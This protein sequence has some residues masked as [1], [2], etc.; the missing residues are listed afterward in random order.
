MYHL[1]LPLYMKDIIRLIRTSTSM[2]SVKAAA[3]V[4]VPSLFFRMF[5]VA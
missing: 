2:W 1:P 5:P 3:M 4:S